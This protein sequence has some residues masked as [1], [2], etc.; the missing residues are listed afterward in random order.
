MHVRDE[1]L[2]ICSFLA[3]HCNLSFFYILLHLMDI[4]SIIILFNGKYVSKKEIQWKC[5]SFFLIFSLSEPFK[6]M[7]LNGEFSELNR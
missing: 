6:Q 5:P 2:K 1:V 4:L 3:R 7:A